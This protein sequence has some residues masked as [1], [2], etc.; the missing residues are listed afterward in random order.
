MNQESDVEMKQYFGLK[1]CLY[2]A[3]FL[4]GIDAFKDAL[5]HFNKGETFWALFAGTAAL[6]CVY[7][8][9]QTYISTILTPEKRKNNK[10][11][12]HDSTTPI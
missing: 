11:D 3:I 10:K 1:F 6:G 5:D 8:W 7:V 9:Y 12:Q 2:V 4:M